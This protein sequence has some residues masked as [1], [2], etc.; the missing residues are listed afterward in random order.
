MTMLEYVTQLRVGTACQML[1]STDRAIGAIA[2]DAGF[3]TLAHFNR[4]FLR[5]KGMTP[6]Q[7]RRE[8][9][10]SSEVHAGR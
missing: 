9:R 7:F 5:S 3:G 8:F 2:G 6:S 10:L 4:Q 1:I